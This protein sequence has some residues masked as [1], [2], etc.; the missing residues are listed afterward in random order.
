MRYLLREVLGDDVED[1]EARA[2]ALLA[3]LRASQV[4]DNTEE[5]EEYMSQDGALIILP[6]AIL[7]IGKANGEATVEVPEELEEDLEAI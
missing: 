7:D 5:W 3:V 1:V 6:K 2:Q 4:V